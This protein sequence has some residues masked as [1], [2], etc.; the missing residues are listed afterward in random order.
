ML[1]FTDV[2]VLTCLT[3]SKAD[4]NKVHAVY[5]I[6]SE[7]LNNEDTIKDLGVYF[8]TCFNSSICHMFLQV[9]Q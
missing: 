9:L 5:F 6:G 1:T 4:C 7:K 8:D 2:N 3:P